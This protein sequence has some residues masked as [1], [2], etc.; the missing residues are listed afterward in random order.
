MPRPGPPSS[1]ATPASSSASSSRARDRASVQF[2]DFSALRWLIIASANDDSGLR[3]LPDLLRPGLDL[4][5][6]GINP[7]SYSAA[8][9][10]YYARRGNLF[11]WAL[12][13]SGLVE[14]PVTPDMD[15]TLLRVGIGFTDVA[16]RPSNAA[17]D[18]SRAEF[19]AGASALV[20]KLERFQP[21]VAC[22]N[23]I[24]AC[25]HCFGPGIAPGPQRQRIGR[26][27]IYVVPSTSRRNAHYQKDDIL[28]WFRGLK[29]FLERAQEEAL[30]ARV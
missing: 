27:R 10:H 17:S 21:L 13:Q 18:L 19:S 12:G 8:R 28:H 30:D 14:G 23:G 20:K 2:Q 4:V 5:F 24:S 9:G 15:A 11:W 22:F 26:T 29:D 1:A 25:V 3:T 16:K 6:A 7:G